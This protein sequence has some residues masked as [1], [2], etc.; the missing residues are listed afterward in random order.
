ML[1]HVI[2]LWIL[3]WGFYP[4]LSGWALNVITRLYDCQMKDVMIK[5][6]EEKA[7]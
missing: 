4:G 6:E 2:K 5:A 7:M 1:P 3:A